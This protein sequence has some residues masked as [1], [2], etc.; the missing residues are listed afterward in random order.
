MPVVGANQP[1]SA[2]SGEIEAI[3][4]RAFGSHAHLDHAD[5]VG[6][7]QINDVRMITLAT[8]ERHILR[9][10]P[11][12]ATAARGPSWFTP[13]G[14]RRE[15][16]VIAAAESLGEFLPVTI[17][18]DFDRAEIDRDWVIQEVM[19]GRPLPDLDATLDE[20][21]RAS[22]WEQVGEFTNRLHST[23]GSY[24][25]PPVCGPTFERWSDLVASDAAGLVRDAERFS[26]PVSMFEQ[27]ANLSGRLAPVLDEV[28]TPRLTHSDLSPSHVFVEI[29]D[30]GR[31]V[32][33][34][35]IDLEFGRFADPLS[36]HLP[37]KFDRGNVPKPMR[38]TF[39]RGYGGH[40]PASGDDVRT[41]IYL[42][43]GLS[44]VATL[45]AYQR[46]STQPLL[47]QLRAVTE[48][49]GEHV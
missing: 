18:H 34:G 39:L 19:P 1:V 28:T 48:R 29:D 17:A 7:A 45:L 42:A 44:W 13:H 23:K 43:I 21:A 10:A 5:S 4:R 47:T 49:L 22:S 41:S 20:Q 30:A 31:P 46:C 12:D 2:T 33:S 25:G 36:E 40:V 27:L 15:Q 6:G 16:A 9:I 32:L 3:V 37:P 26:L 24:F 38:S 8:G 35:V 11:S 14:L